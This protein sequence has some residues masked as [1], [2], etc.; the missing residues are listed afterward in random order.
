MSITHDETGNP[1]YNDS[2]SCEHFGTFF[3]VESLS[4]KY[5]KCDTLMN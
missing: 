1:N 3:F 4:H 5:E 2:K